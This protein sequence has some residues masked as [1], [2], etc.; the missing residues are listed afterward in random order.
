MNSLNEL[1]A[2][3]SAFGVIE[4]YSHYSKAVTPGSPVPTGG[5]LLK[6]YDIAE[7]ATPVTAETCALAQ[8]FLAAETATGRLNLKGELG[9]VIL[10][11]CGA[12]FHFLLV[13]SWRNANEMWETVYAKTSEA[14]DF[15]L[16]AL[17]G[18]HRAT[19]CVWELAAVNHERE[20][21]GRYLFSRRDD[22]AKRAYLADMYRGGA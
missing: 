2:D 7:A 16:F 11:R 10:H 12:D 14:P 4:G 6:W 5:G 8:R 13:S 3:L 1:P 20:A 19:F 15:S 21:F 9:F 18:P 22:A 17:P